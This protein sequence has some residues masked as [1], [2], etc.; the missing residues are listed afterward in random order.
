MNAAQALFLAHGVGPTTIE[1]ITS[2]ADV[3]KGTF[4]L[5]FSSKDDVLIG[6]R[7]R[8]AEELLVKIR[9]AVAEKPKDDWNGKLAT[10]AATGVAGYLE[11]IRLH[12]ILFYGSSR[13]STREGVIN[14]IVVDHL[15]E[16]LE[17]GMDAGAWSLDDVRSTAVF[18]FSGLHGV[19]D[20][21]Y[22]KPNRVNRTQLARR[23]QRLCFRAVGLPPGN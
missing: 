5:H 20:D 19:I 21:A 16:L 1:Q 6:L 23:V 7:E 13:P 8:F 4:Y 17:G 18:L 3:A 11:S 10:W 14:N 9:A 12:D 2:A 22:M 15:V